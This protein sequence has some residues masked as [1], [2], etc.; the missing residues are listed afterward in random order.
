MILLNKIS[1]LDAH[2][3]SLISILISF[4]F[5]IF[6]NSRLSS[7]ILITLLWDVFA[8]C[9]L[10][11]SWIT[12]TNT[13]VNEIRNTA[14]TQDAGRKTIFVLIVGAACISLLAVG[15][16]LGEAKGTSIGNLSSHILLAASSVI[17]SWLLIHTLY[18]LRYAHVFYGD[19]NVTGEKE[20]HGGL[21]FPGEKK[22]DYMDFA[23]FSFVVGMT[24]QVSDVQVTSKRM[25]RLVLLHG[26]I[27]FAF[28]TAILALII[29]IIA[30]LL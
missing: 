5:F 30:S 2:Y 3:R 16:L 4:L 22:P 18:S 29:N 27:S 20:Y 12:L 15:F 13:E 7:I 9:S 23:Y 19:R 14:R 26:I 1:K 11:L 6:L 17:C 24:C 10:I 8:V 28:N 25:R 21:D